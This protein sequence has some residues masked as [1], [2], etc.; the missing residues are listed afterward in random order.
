MR[1]INILS[2][3][4][5]MNKLCNCKKRNYDIKIVGALYSMLINDYVI[6]TPPRPS[7]I[8]EKNWSTNPKT[9]LTSHL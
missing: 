9:F 7:E 3:K 6:Y 4:G 1:K 5:L 2:D 8:S